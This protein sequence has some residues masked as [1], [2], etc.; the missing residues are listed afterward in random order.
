MIHTFPR[1]A[2]RS[3]VSDGGAV[4]RRPARL[5]SRLSAAARSHVGRSLV[6]RILAALLLA[7]SLAALFAAADREWVVPRFDSSGQR[8]A[9]RQFPYPYHA[10]AAL[11]NDC[12]NLTL[13]A[14]ERYHRFLNTREETVYGTGLGLDVTDSFFPYSAA[15]D[16]AALM[17]YYLGLDPETPKEARRIRRYFECGWIDTLHTFGDFS[18]QN[19]NTESGQAPSESTQFGFDLA[20]AALTGLW[21]DRLFPLVWTDHGNEGNVQN[22]GSYHPATS[23][24]YQRGDDKF[25]GAYYHT[26]LTLAGGGVKYI[27]HS[28]HSGRFGAD[29]PAFAATLRDGQKVWAFDRF[30]GER[31]A[32]GEIEWLWYPDWLADELTEARLASVAENRQYAL[33]AQHLGFYGEDYRIPEQG[34]E[35]LRRLAAWQNEKNEILVAGTARL[36]EY[37]TMRKF[38]RYRARAGADGAAE[39]DILAI[40]DPLFPEAAPDLARLRGLTFYCDDA[41]RARLLVNG[42]PVGESEIKRNAADETGRPSLSIKWFEPDYTDFSAFG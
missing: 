6:V 38:V 31:G 34:I 19:E 17:T 25:S 33:F 36:L 18:T 23:S 41:D 3:A 14:F 40:D 15:A 13:R 20:S 32:N 12:D 21:R 2:A 11:V 27:W 26:D 42:E 37:A 5:V 30:T 10:M 29:F 7:A 24:R 1:A 22:F 35:A 8:V 39:I 28:R 4:I 9:L 16:S